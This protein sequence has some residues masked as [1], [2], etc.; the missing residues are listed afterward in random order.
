MNMMFHCNPTFENSVFI[1]RSPLVYPDM[2]CSVSEYKILC[3]S[4]TGLMEHRDEE[5]YNPKIPSGTI[6]LEA[7]RID[8]LG[9]VYKQLPFEIHTSAPWPCTTPTRA[10][11][12]SS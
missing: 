6:E 7:H 10:A 3:L 12:S 2:V 9:R 11:S 5:T 8:V 1:T 4:I